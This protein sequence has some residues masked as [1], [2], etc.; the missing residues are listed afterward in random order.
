ML[1]EARTGG[2]YGQRMTPEE[3]ADAHVAETLALAEAVAWGEPGVAFDGPEEYA[4]SER[5]QA[6]VFL[7]RV[8]EYVGL[9]LQD[10]HALAQQ[11]R[12][13][14]CPHPVRGHRADL[15]SRR[16]HVLVEQDHVVSAALDRPRWLVGVLP[17]RL[18]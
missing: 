7:R 12:D 2:A 13:R 8:D 11:R 14:L 18:W 4:A 15:D 9:S 17:D 6:E 3:A 5:A 16:V 1:R 10:A